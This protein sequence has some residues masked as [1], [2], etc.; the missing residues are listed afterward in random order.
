MSVNP[1]PLAGSGLPRR[2]KVADDVVCQTFEDQI[3]LLNLSSQEYFGL[4]EVGSHAWTLLAE[5]G[6]IDAVATRL[7][8]DFTG[9]SVAIQDD[10]H[11][12][13]RELIDAGLVQA[14]DA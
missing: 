3:V 4:D 13:V 11:I 1:S 9:D 7:C 10:F 12:L 2:V 5:A 8:V 6:D 14:I